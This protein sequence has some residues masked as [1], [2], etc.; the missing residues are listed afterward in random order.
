ML[1]TTTLLGDLV[2]DKL[3]LFLICCSKEFMIG[4]IGANGVDLPC[5]DIVSRE[6]FPRRNRRLRLALFCRFGLPIGI[7]ALHRK[8][9]VVFFGFQ[10]H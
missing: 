4:L 8:T 2:V 1:V 5:T 6:C 9:S 3:A 10:I 7:R